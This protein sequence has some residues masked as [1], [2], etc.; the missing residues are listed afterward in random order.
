M[1]PIEFHLERSADRHEPFTWRVYTAGA[2]EMLA[3]AENYASR[4]GMINAVAAVQDGKTVYETFQ[5]KD[6]Y[7][8]FH[9]QGLN[10]ETLARSARRYRTESEAGS[11]SDLIE[12]NAATAPVLDLTK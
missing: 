4:A 10:G 5:G 8:Y 6:R 7:W 9:I 3:Y 12:A 11:I 2:A 1:N